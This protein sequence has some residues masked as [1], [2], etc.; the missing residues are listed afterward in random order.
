ML[1][2][3]TTARVKIDQAIPN[4]VPC[5]GCSHRD[6]AVASVQWRHRLLEIYERGVSL[7]GMIRTFMFCENNLL[8]G[9]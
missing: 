4:M 2:Q 8:G 9:H 7:R 6:A 5:T 1:K 3:S